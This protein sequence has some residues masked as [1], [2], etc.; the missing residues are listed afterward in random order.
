MDPRYDPIFLRAPILQGIHN[1][2]ARKGIVPGLEKY[3]LA[4]FFS[5][6]GPH[7]EIRKTENE[8]C[9]ALAVGPSSL[10]GRLQSVKRQGK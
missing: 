6:V 5:P 9:R 3:D 1:K 4:S 7:W 2:A 8:A 10:F